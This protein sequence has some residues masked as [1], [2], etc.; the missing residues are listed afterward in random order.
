[1]VSEH[2]A[3]NRALRE[4]GYRCRRCGAR[5]PLLVQ[6]AGAELEVLCAK[7][8]TRGELVPV[9]VR[10]FSALLAESTEPPEFASFAEEAKC[11][12][13]RAGIPLSVPDYNAAMDRFGER[14]PSPVENKQP[15]VENGQ[16]IGRAEAAAILRRV[17]AEGVVRCMPPARVPTRRQVERQKALRIVMAAIAEQ[18]D[19]CEAV[20]R[21]E[22]CRSEC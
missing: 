2:A 21:E 18:V 1:M 10:I 6:P 13:V 15:P 20:E 12:I 17:R 5:R 16:P 3:R 9:Y 19:V 7:C 22:P 11:R 14:F 4:A 8:A